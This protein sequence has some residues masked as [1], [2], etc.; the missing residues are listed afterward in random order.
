VLQRDIQD[1]AKIA[2]ATAV[3]RLLS[4][5]AARAGGQLNFAGLPRTMALS[6]TTLKHYFALREATFLVQLLHLWARNLRQRA[7]QTP[8]LYPND[9]GLLAN[10]LRVTVD[11]MKAEGKVAGSVSENLV[12][13]E[14]RQQCALSATRPGLF[15]WRT[16]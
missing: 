15:Y 8:E 9:R 14:L 5:V 2:D 1:L 4:V 10:L 12:L 3:P 11:R 16:A 6:Q 13:M 7:I